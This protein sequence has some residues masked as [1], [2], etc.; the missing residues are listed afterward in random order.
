M[1]YCDRQRQREREVGTQSI[2]GKSNATKRNQYV[3]KN[4]NNENERT[5]SKQRKK[6]GIKPK[7]ANTARYIEYSTGMTQSTSTIIVTVLYWRVWLW[8]VYQFGRGTRRGNTVMD[9]YG[10]RWFEFYFTGLYLLYNNCFD[11]RLRIRETN[12][13]IQRQ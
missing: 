10:Y 11:T 8:C 2:G 1:C 6:G 9:G 13:H 3:T 5:K 4:Q 7:I 12:T